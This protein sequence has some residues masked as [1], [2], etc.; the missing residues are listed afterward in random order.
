MA[1][2]SAL[3]TAASCAGLSHTPAAVVAQNPDTHTPRAG[4][5]AGGGMGDMDF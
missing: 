3:N 1:P 5:G 2:G 4:P